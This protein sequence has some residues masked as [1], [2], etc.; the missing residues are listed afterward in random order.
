MN[1]LSDDSE[2]Q[3]TNLKNLEDNEIASLTIIESRRLQNVSMFTQIDTCNINMTNNVT[4]D[5]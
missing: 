2:T 5:M 4:M 3:V 1:G